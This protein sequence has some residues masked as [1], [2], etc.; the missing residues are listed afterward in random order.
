MNDIVD[1]INLILQNLNKHSRNKKQ[2]SF[3]EWYNTNNNLFKYMNEGV[4][5][6]EPYEVR[7]LIS[8]QTK[9]MLDFMMDRYKSHKL[10]NLCRIYMIYSLILNFNT[11]DKRK[12]IM[13][14]PTQG[15]TI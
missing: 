4:N 15:E 9:R 13:N 11:D 12:K 8:P 3:D 6:K 10:E 14:M 7:F 1:D 2:V 5:D